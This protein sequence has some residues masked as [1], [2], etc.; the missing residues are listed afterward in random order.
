M[1]AV[2]LS[3]CLVA[4]PAVCRTFRIPLSQGWDTKTCA[5]NAQPY[6][7]QWSNEHPGWKIVK[8]R[9]ATGDREE[10]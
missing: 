7:G 8:W 10:I 4:D 3:A 5:M 2:I 9:C 1:I 6:F